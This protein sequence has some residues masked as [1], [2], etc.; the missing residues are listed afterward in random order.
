VIEK[1]CE[2]FNATEPIFPRT[3]LRLL[4]KLGST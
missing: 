3:N 1:L 2:E 4:L